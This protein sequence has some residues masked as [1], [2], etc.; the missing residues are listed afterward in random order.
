MVSKDNETNSLSHRR[1][2][3]WLRRISFICPWVQTTSLHRS[4]P[5]HKLNYLHSIDSL[6]V[7]TRLVDTLI[8][9][10]GYLI[11][12]DKR[13]TIDIQLG[14][15]SIWLFFSH[16]YPLSRWAIFS[17]LSRESLSGRGNT[18]CQLPTKTD[19]NGPFFKTR[20]KQF[21]CSF[22]TYLRNEQNSI[23]FIPLPMA[24]WTEYG[25]SE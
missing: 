23:L 21:S 10:L 24:E 1:I 18:Y 17:S 12:Q 14:A 8:F 13:D 19:S 20:N 15:L 7:N 11:K 3:T 5:T 25:L 16:N 2:I 9:S 6:K 4:S 22:G